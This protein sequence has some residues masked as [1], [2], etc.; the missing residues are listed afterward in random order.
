MDGQYGLLYLWT[1]MDLLRNGDGARELPVA[2]G[3]HE[4]GDLKA[5]AV[6]IDMEEVYHRHHYKQH[7][8][9]SYHFMSCHM[10][11]INTTHGLAGYDNRVS[12]TSCYEVH[13]V[14]ILIV[15]N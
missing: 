15:T 9:V 1:T 13:L 8:H 4:V 14:V 7:L 12:L 11:Y 6:L 2:E 5:R 10:I 3:K